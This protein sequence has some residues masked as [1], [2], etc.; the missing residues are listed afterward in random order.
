MDNMASSRII[1]PAQKTSIWCRMDFPALPQDKLEDK[2]NDKS[3]EAS[4]PSSIISMDLS[5]KK[6]SINPYQT[7]VISIIYPYEKPSKT[8]K[9]A[10]HSPWWQRVLTSNDGEDS[11]LQ[12][13]AICPWSVLRPWLELCLGRMAILR[14]EMWENVVKNMGRSWFMMI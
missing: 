12:P 11:S 4:Y 2:S 5:L 9:K 10:I 14:G 3:I 6:S 1:F 7:M 13:N 8:L